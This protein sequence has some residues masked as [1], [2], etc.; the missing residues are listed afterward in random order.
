MEDVVVVEVAHTL[1][2]EQPHRVQHVEQVPMQP[3][4]RDHVLHV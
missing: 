1:L 4:L 3:Q 2:E